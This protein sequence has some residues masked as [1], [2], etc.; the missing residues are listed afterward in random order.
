[1]GISRTFSFRL[2]VFIL[3]SRR[4]LPHMGERRGLYDAEREIP[5]RSRR[6]GTA[7]LV[8]SRVLCGKSV[9]YAETEKSDETDHLTYFRR[10]IMKKTKK[11]V[12]FVLALVFCFSAMSYVVFAGGES[13]IKPMATDHCPDHPDAGWGTSWGSTPSGDLIH[14]YTCSVCGFAFDWDFCSFTGYGDC[15]APAY[16]MICFQEKPNRPE[17]HNFS[18]WKPYRL[19]HY[20]VCQNEDCFVEQQQDH[21]RD[22]LFGEVGGPQYPQCTVCGYVFQD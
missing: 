17:D 16:C 13:T 14:Y 3:Y 19:Y 10:K 6:C 22:G 12:S 4:G 1:M 18:E 11:A 5:R 9:Q 7:A 15:Q 8:Q 21:N 20:R 2:C